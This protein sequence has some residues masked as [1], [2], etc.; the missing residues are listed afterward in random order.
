[1]NDF[2][3]ITLTPESYQVDRDKI[4]NVLNNRVYNKKVIEFYRKYFTNPDR[5]LMLSPHKVENIERCNKYFD[6]DIYQEEM[7]QE[8]L[9]T[10]LCKDKFCN[11]CKKVKQ[12]SRMSRYIKHIEPYSD[13]CYH[14]VLTVPSVTS[15]RS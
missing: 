6:T 12:A 7:I 15:D 10:N 1:M 13:L 5:V 11:N 2:D 3:S 4:C 8:I 14:L 9:R